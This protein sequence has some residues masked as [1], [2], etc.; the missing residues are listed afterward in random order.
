MKPLAAALVGTTLAIAGTAQATT[1]RVDVTIENLAPRDGT[2]QTPHW[3]G[4][5]DGSF[6]VYDGGT[7]ADNDPVPNDPR[8]SVERLAED[9]NTG[10]ISET[11]REL[12]P[13]GVDSTIAGPDGALGPGQI[14]S[15]SFLLDAHDP[16]LRYF[17]YA[18][19]VLPSNDFWYANGNPLAHPIF[20]EAGEFVAEDF[21]VTNL[22][23]L[24]AGTE[25]NDEVP[26]N[27]AFF[28]QQ[29]PNTGVDENGVIVDLFGE[30]GEPQFGFLP[31]GSGGILDDPR[32]AMADFTLRGYPVVKI[33][34]SATPAVVDDHR[35][36]TRLTGE[37]EVPPVHTDAYGLAK[38]FF[39]ADE[40]ALSFV[41]LLSLH[42]RDIVAAHLHLG[43]EGENGPVVAS[44][45][46][47][48]DSAGTLRRASRAEKLLYVTALKGEI[49][50]EDLVGPLQGMPIDALI[51]A[52]KDGRVY[53]NVHTKTHPDGEVR[54][55]L[56]AEGRSS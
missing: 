23:L 41:H 21:F 15:Q 42:R 40:G 44:L 43:V 53:V 48:R 52:T 24:D 54:G 19:M 39:D 20:D 28:G 18:S 27:T 51:A 9:G 37:A 3:V 56:Y 49:D 1:Y 10:P 25:V 38:Y 7:P 6:D 16:N 12:L 8:K 13:S 30:D 26:A 22:D 36:V 4:F 31:K 29:E 55:Q 5:H 45:F 47:E 46:D 17:S 14:T 50:S 34:F 33:S 11:F 2:F 35:F 32:F